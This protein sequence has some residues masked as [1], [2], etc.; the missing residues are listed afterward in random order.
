MQLELPPHPHADTADVALATLRSG[1]GGL[2]SHEAAARLGQFGPNALPTPPRVTLGQILLHQFQSPLIYLLLLAA[3]VALALGE[4]VDAAF[5]GAVLL[6]NAV[7]GTLQEYGAERS[8]E[9]LAKLVPARARAVRD[10]REMSVDI[11]ELVPGD[12]VLAEAGVRVPADLRLLHSASV[13]ADESLLTGE[14]LAVQKDAAA[15]HAP[16]CQTV[17]RSNMLHAGTM[18]TRGRARGLVVATGPGTV[19][20]HL[21]ASMAAARTARPPL[22][23]RMERFART[24]AVAVGVLVA[25]VFALG[26]VRDMAVEEIVLACIALAVSAIPEGLPV[27]L[28]VAL[29]IATRR[30]SRRGVIARRLVAVES[31]GSCTFIA[32]D[33]TG[34]LTRNELTVVSVVLAGPAGRRIDVEGVGLSGAG[35][36]RDRSTGLELEPEDPALRHLLTLG[37]FTN[38]AH[39][40]LDE[41]GALHAHDGD[42][43]DLALL[44]LAAKAG[45]R[46]EAL[47]GRHEELGAIPF[48]PDLRLSASVRPGEDGRPMISVKG[49]PE[50]VLSMCN[51]SADAREALLA[52]VEDLAAAGQRVLALASAP[53]P[54]DPEQPSVDALDGLELAGLVGMIDP[55][56]DEARAAVARCAE[57]GVAVA[58]V[59][60]DHPITALAISRELGLAT[61][62]SQVVT[63]PALSDA[64]AAGDEAVRALV[65][66][67][68]VFAR[69][70]PAQKLRIVQT[71]A[72]LGHFVAVTGDGA[73]D[74]PALRAAHV[75]VAMGE[76]GTDIAREASGL[77]LTDDNFAS[78]VAGI[79]EGRV[80]YTNVRKVTFLLIATGLSEVLFFLAA[81]AL[82]L[83]VPFLP[84]QLLW[85][86]LVTNGIQDVALAFEPAEGHE[87]RIPPRPPRERIFDAVMI[88]RVLA[89]SV[90]M[91]AASTVA[92]DTLLAHGYDEFTARG[93]LLFGFVVFEN[94]VVGAARSET[95][96]VLTMNPLRNRVLLVGTVVAFGLHV[97]AMYTP[98][99]SDV[100]RIGP[101]PAELWGMAF[102]LGLTSFAVLE[103]Q[104]HLRR[105]RA[106]RR[107][108]RANG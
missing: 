24:I 23:I 16:S 3:A 44:V 47:R 92:F 49:A 6:L 100:L 45:L 2:T 15:L 9:A 43:V 72:S 70:E 59:T 1:H 31:L 42:A 62:L 33:K 79:E 57:A 7:I 17:E 5:I 53:W 71:L 93:A 86:N 11:A 25:I 50:R 65:S 34:T 89:V 99:L 13:Q 28:T 60:G 26:M 95:A 64:E 46:W 39:L 19:L 37:V 80:A 68:R 78:I 54:G 58:M 108:I 97:G 98:G 63:G 12:V 18:V 96:P 61:E 107:P 91:A 77:I 35:A 20:G 87:L 75:G 4:H 103:G 104:T 41:A 29:S 48:D 21:A 27:G 8:A 102:L 56:R 74:A 22:L 76:R 10:G 83:P 82:G 73:N 52:T 40:E 66:G 105:W 69:V 106:R 94:L 88:Q 36:F 14:S 30:M 67:A 51:L 55:L 38:D 101:L 84:A 85:L 81:M 32:S 90:W